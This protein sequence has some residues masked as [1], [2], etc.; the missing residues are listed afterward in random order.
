MSS[1]T[2]R[3]FGSNCVLDQREDM[4]QRP[5]MVP[6]AGR[7]LPFEVAV[8]DPST[9]ASDTVD[10][11]ISDAFASIRELIGMSVPTNRVL[12]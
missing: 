2:G 3:P 4:K 5:V 9:C 8:L 11:R 7:T 1:A 6:L 10:A 12:P